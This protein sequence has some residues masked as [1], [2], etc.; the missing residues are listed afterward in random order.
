LGKFVKYCKDHGIVYHFI[1]LDTPQHNSVEER[2]NM[3][4]VE[5]ARSMIKGKNLSNSF[6]AKAIST[7]VYLNNRI[8]TRYLD[9]KTPFEALYGFKLAV[10]HLRIFG[11]KAFAHILKENRKKLD[12]KSI[13]C[14]FVGYC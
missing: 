1:V 10:H 3:T 13:K 8:P 11:C 5:C 12:A 2:K 4:L 7:V 6:W 14:I 9:F